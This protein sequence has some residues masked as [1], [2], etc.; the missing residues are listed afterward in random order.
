[1]Y[2][3]TIG[4]LNVYVKVAGRNQTNAWTRVGQQG[5]Q[6]LVDY[7]DIVTY[8]NGATQY[9]LIFEAVRGSSFT[10]DIALDDLLF[11]PCGK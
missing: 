1:M 5:N 8:L 4:S 10:S 6:W 9:T 2:G 3:A 7:V 11:G